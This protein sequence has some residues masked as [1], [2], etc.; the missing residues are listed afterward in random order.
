MK[1]FFK[2]VILILLSFHFSG[3]DIKAQT[4]EEM[5]KQIEQLQK[6]VDEQEVLIKKYEEIIENDKKKVK[7][8]FN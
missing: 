5:K 2:I 7:G 8:M 4:E 3:C 6:K 1:L